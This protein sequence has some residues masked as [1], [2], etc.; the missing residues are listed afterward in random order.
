MDA[1]DVAIIILGSLA[2][3]TRLAGARFF[4][5]VDNERACADGMRCRIASWAFILVIGVMLIISKDFDMPVR[6]LGGIFSF[7]SAGGVVWEVITL[8]NYF[9]DKR[10]A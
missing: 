4:A 6:I 8:V 9:N 5:L 7:L 3:A 1:F 10:S 2:L